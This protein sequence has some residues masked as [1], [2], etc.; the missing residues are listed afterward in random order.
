MGGENDRKFESK[1]NKGIRIANKNNAQ[2]VPLMTGGL[3]EVKGGMAAHEI[4][5]G[6]AKDEDR[7]KHVVKEGGIEGRSGKRALE[8]GIGRGEVENG[9]GGGVEEGRKKG[10]E[11]VVEILEA[12]YGRM[13]IGRCVQQNYGFLGCKAEVTK[14]VADACD[15][16]SS[17]SFQ[18][19]PCVCFLIEF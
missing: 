12:W 8:A 18:V 13:H 19:G 2:A 4:R 16:R 5:S 17:C 3:K 7:A 15:A 10:V 14:I 6:L 11:G 9:K 1:D